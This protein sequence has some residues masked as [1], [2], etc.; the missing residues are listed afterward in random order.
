[1]EFGDVSR[2]TLQHCC[3]NWDTPWLIWDGTG[4]KF[5]NDDG[6]SDR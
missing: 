3:M 2:Y 5:N 6:K 4:G 1:V